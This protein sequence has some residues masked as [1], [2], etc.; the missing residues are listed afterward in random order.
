MQKRKEPKLYFDS[1]KELFDCLEY[2]MKRLGLSDWYI[3]ARICSAKDMGLDDVAGEADVQHCNM[4][5]AISILREKDI[6]SN[7]LLKQ[8]HEQTL[9]HELLHFK[10]ISFE[11]DD[12]DNAVYEE[13]QHQL[14]ELLSRALFMARY[15]LSPEW[16]VKHTYKEES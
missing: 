1:E 15:D 7:T 14:I 10:F 9:I 13:H 6:P 3:A 5:G 16:F 4:C 2:W 8:P 11:P 12:R